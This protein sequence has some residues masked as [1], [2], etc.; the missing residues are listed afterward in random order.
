MG[1][2][3]VTFMCHMYV[4]LKELSNQPIGLNSGP[5]RATAQ[6]TIVAR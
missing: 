3:Y 2:P 5:E 1:M 6:P 4:Q